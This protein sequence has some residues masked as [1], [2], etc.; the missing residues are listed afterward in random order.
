MLQGNADINHTLTAGLMCFYEKKRE[1][2]VQSFSWKIIDLILSWGIFTFNN[3]K[4][5][6]CKSWRKVRQELKMV[7]NKHFAYALI[8]NCN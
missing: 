6:C 8:E 7:A 4:I 3:L 5:L 2:N 1:N